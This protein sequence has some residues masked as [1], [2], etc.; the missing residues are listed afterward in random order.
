MIK[1]MFMS[2]IKGAIFDIDGT[3]LDS[4]P[5]WDSVAADYLVSRGKTPKPDLN[6]QLR[7]IGGHQMPD[8]FRDA[9]GISETADEIQDAMGELLEDFY[10][11][12]APLKD[13][14]LS[15]LQSFK[16]RGI[17]M[18]AATATDRYLIEP[19][20]QR[21]GIN[22]FFDRIFT[23]GEE[24]TSKSSP[25]I[26]LKAVEFLGTGISETLVFEDA[27]Y[28]IRTVKKLGFPLVA[29][30]DLSAAKHQDEILDLCDKYFK[31]LID[32]HEFIE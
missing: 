10:F 13:G 21:V 15:V 29:V 28:A 11:N 4:M 24:M 3:L 22:G 16:D 5:I 14:A 27:L 19:A 20:L 7:K 17:K 18:C 26:F 6:E 1:R 23:C 32:F 12:V 30:Y 2:D 8:F 31:S 25:E 9:Y